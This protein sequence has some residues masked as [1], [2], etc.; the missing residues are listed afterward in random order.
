[1]VR[2]ISLSAVAPDET[3]SLIRLDREIRVDEYSLLAKG[4]RYS[5]EAD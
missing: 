1:M 2:A 5:V 3:N 4:H